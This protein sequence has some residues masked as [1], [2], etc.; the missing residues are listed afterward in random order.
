MVAAEIEA[1]KA[2]ST[3]HKTAHM[4]TKRDQTGEA[5]KGELMNWRKTKKQRVGLDRKARNEAKSFNFSV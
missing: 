4:R 2:G 1:N 5:E 3:P